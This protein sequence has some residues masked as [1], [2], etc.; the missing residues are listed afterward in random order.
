MTLHW[1]ECRRFGVGFLMT[2]FML[3]DV[4]IVGMLKGF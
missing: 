2:A 3:T 1:L 4:W